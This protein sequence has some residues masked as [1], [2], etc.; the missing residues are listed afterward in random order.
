MAV[1]GEARTLR[2]AIAGSGLTTAQ[3]LARVGCTRKSL[4]NWR[5]GRR[6]SD[7]YIGRLSEVLGT[8]LWPIFDK[9]T[10]RNRAQEARVVGQR[11]ELLT[12]G[13][14]T[15]NWCVIAL[16]HF[17]AQQIRCSYSRTQ[18]V[19]PDDIEQLRAAFVEDWEQR[20][21]RGETHLPFNSQMYKL[22]EFDAG[23]RQMVDGEEVPI[24]R[25]RFGPT[26]YFT[27]IVTDL[28]ITNPARNHY[29]DAAN[30][31]EKPVPEFASILGVNLSL[32]T[33][34]GYLIVSERSKHAYLAGG[35]LHTSV[36]ENILRP[37]DAGVDGAPD[38]FRAAARGA[39][40]E[41]GIQFDAQSLEFG[42]FG[43][44]PTL[45][46]YSLFATH[47]IS[48]TRDD[49][50]KLRGFGAP[51]DKWES[52]RLLFV[53]F[54]PEDVAIFVAQTKEQWLPIGLAA[55]ILGLWQVGY[56]LAVIEAAFS[57]INSANR[58]A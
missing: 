35:R 5:G 55:I 53:P 16:D 36:A 49:I 17:A 41:L 7:Y 56:S 26:D 13:G 4:S 1:Q 10:T 15:V 46:Q 24:L 12:V 32:V 39:H 42:A 34:D 51:K 31:T 57:A 29:A 52:S 54:A 43:F 18:A 45:C 19:L 9:P 22:L 30:L 6:P 50:L 23:F 44:E 48:Q 14:I 33:A 3:I 38:P 11:Y 58:G 20:N 21:Q 27:Q 8:D 47:R 25:L 37:L 2:E 28:N 40:E